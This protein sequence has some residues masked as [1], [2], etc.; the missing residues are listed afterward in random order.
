MITEAE[1]LATKNTRLLFMIRNLGRVVFI[2][3]SQLC[4]GGCPT[5]S[6]T[7]KGGTWPE[8]P[9]APN[10]AKGAESPEGWAAPA[11]VRA[12]AVLGSL[13][14]GYDTRFKVFQYNIRHAFQ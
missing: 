6:V 8:K 10:H 5:A 11:L 14:Y 7:G 4:G 1:I 2:E 3:T 9:T 12:H 13:C